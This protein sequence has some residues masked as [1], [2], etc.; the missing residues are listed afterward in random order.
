MKGYKSHPGQSLDNFQFSTYDGRL[1]IVQPHEV[2]I[3]DVRYL[4]ELQK[5]IKASDEE[6]HILKAPHVQKVAWLP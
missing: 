1:A 3:F 6:Q 4:E 5:Q 2:V